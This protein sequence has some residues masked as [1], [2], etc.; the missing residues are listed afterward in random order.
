MYYD[1]KFECV[2]TLRTVTVT[3]M[4]INKAEMDA[5]FQLKCDKIRFIHKSKNLIRTARGF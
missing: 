1:F 5:K 3:A 2:K 4:S